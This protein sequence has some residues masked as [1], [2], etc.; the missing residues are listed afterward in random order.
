MLELSLSMTVPALR[1]DAYALLIAW[2]CIDLLWVASRHTQ[3]AKTADRGSLFFIVLAFWGSIFLAMTLAYRRVGEF[4][5][6]T[7]YV[8]LAG[9]AFM[10]CGMA[11]RGLAIHQLGRLHMP[12]VAIQADHPL[13]DKGL[14]GVVRHPSYLGATLA[15]LGFG[16]ALGSWPAALVT[17]AGAVFGYGYRIHVEE[18]ALVKGLGERY[19]QYMGRTK[20][21]IPWLY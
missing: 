15:F 14:Y 2:L 9:F 11:I 3:G 4:G 12:V 16:L 5:A 21:F 20:R 13:M 1:S 6:A 17:L 8:Q 10:V 19:V 7:V 18:Q